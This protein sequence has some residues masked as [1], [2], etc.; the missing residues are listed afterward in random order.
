MEQATYIA[1]VAYCM[2]C[3]LL[4]LTL[5]KQKGYSEAGWFF[6]GVLTGVLG[7]I[8]IAGMPLTATAASEIQK[9]IAAKLKA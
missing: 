7:L 1:I 6:V 2:V 4:S 8:A 3:G 5:A 9:A